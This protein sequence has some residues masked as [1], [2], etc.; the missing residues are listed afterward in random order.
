MKKEIPS[1]QATANS[2]HDTGSIL[3]KGLKDSVR[4]SVSV[5]VLVGVLWGLLQF[6]DW[7]IAAYLSNERILEDIAR[8]ARPY[9]IFNQAGSVLFDGGAMEY[10]SEPPKVSLNVPEGYVISITIS[11]KRHMGTPPIIESLTGHVLYFDAKR[12][13]GFQWILSAGT[14]GT[15]G[16]RSFSVGNEEDIVLRMEILRGD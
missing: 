9:V 10:L 11:P 3:W 5:L 14:S 4:V 15:M 16:G 7:R 6:V 1:E 8:R 2:P 12:G 13:E